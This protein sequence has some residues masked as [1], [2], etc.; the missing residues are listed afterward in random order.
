MDKIKLTDI[1]VAILEFK[2][3]PTEENDKKVHEYMQKLQIIP[4]LGIDRKAICA[5]IIAGN[6]FN[7][8]R[9]MVKSGIHLMVAETMYGIL[10]YC[11][12]LEN[13]LDTYVTDETIYDTLCEFGFVDY[14]LQ[15]CGTDFK[16][17]CDLVDKMLNFGNIYKI[18]EAAENFSSDKLDALIGQLKEARKVLTPEMLENMKEILNGQSSEWDALRKAVQEASLSKALNKN[19]DSVLGISTPLHKEDGVKE[20]KK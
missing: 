9:D 1:L 10:E 11:I 5:S 8:D 4:Y 7:V 12:N 14:V 3:N 6:V 18:T 20:D 19:I 15:Y 13:D 16:R 2:K 17:L